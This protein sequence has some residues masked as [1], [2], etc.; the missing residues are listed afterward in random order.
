LYGTFIY[1]DAAI[2]GC[3]L[4][5]VYDSSRKQQKIM[6]K[7]VCKEFCYII[8]KFSVSCTILKYEPE[9]KFGSKWTVLEIKHTVFYYLG[10]FVARGRGLDRID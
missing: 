7:I 6:G 2:N 5:C 4:A 3:H 1:N 10:Q 8:C 9:T